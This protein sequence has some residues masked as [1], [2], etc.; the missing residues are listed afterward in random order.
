MKR[1]CCLCREAPVEIK[2]KEEE[3]DDT[4]VGVEYEGVEE[5][6]RR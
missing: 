5:G 4:R 2:R 6:V 3:K 1:W